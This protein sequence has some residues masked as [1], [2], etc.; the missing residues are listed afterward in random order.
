M[1]VEDNSI[2]RE[3][4]KRMKMRGDTRKGGMGMR[5]T[6]DR[7]NLL[8]QIYGRDVSVRVDDLY[9]NNHKPSGTRVSIRITYSE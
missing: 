5:L 3:R 2:G 7:L 9:D 4:T 1:I 6:T 8:H